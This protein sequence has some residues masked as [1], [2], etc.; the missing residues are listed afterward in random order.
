MQSEAETNGMAVDTHLVF[1]SPS[2]PANFS[3]MHLPQVWGVLPHSFLFKV[4]QFGAKEQ[5][6]KFSTELAVAITC[7]VKSALPSPELSCSAIRFDSCAVLISSTVTSTE[8]PT[9]AVALRASNTLTEHT[10]RFCSASSPAGS[11][12]VP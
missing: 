11:V 12:V 6:T 8:V 5:F 2:S 4:V 3:D 10:T 1:A 7:L 9:D